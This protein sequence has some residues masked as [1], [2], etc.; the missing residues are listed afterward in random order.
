M[1][2]Q[3]T[4]NLIKLT[5]L[6]WVYAGIRSIC[7]NFVSNLI[8][9]HFILQI[10]SDRLLPQDKMNSP[11][12]FSANKENMNKPQT[13]ENRDPYMRLPTKGTNSVA[14]NSKVMNLYRNP[15]N[16]SR[17]VPDTQRDFGRG[18]THQIPDTQRD[19]GRGTTH[20]G[21]AHSYNRTDR[22]PLFSNGGTAKPV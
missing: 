8:S 10:A 14:D 22:K 16:N 19:F 5:P 11:L 20:Q 4:K 13:N 6:V 9:F 15:G 18:T 12:P 3:T 21:S 17:Q 2:W 7:G 1:K